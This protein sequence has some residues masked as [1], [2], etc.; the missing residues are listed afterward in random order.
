MYV[1]QFGLES[2][3]YNADGNVNQV[4]YVDNRTAKAYLTN[5]RARKQWY[6]SVFVFS[7]IDSQEV[8]DVSVDCQVETCG[9]HFV[10]N[11][12]EFVFVRPCKYRIVSVE[13]IQALALLKHT[14]VDHGLLESH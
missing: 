11:C 6:C 13:Y 1:L 8:G 12:V 9:L 7:D 3:L 14:F 5:S 2:D 10:N 4:V